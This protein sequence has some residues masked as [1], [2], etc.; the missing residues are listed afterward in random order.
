M[1]KKDTTYKEE[2]LRPEWIR[3]R[4]AMELFG[5]GRSKI[6]DL[7]AENRIKTVSFR[8]RGAKHGTRLLS[9]KSLA[10]LLDSMAEGGE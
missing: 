4:Q 9:Y 6:Y 10:S 3:V 7:I 5:L 1:K 8:E 2:R